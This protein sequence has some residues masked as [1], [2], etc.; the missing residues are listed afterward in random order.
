M[1]KFY[2]LGAFHKIESKI[3]SVS[4]QLKRKPCLISDMLRLKS[5][6]NLD[7]NGFNVGVLGKLAELFKT[8]L[9]EVGE[10]TFHQFT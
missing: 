3:L 8:S 7:Q 9:E 4:K 6:E 10:K 2:D 1:K 5:T